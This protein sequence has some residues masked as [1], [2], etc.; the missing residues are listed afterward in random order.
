[1]RYA[2]IALV[3]GS[4]V[5]VAGPARAQMPQSDALRLASDVR[6][7]GGNCPA[8]QVDYHATQ[9]F[10]DR[11]GLINVFSPDGPMQPYLVQHDRQLN[12]G[13]KAVGQETMCQSLLDKYRS[14]GLLII[15]SAPELDDL[16]RMRSS[17][18]GG[19]IA[20]LK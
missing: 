5:L 18:G 9:R 7:V 4:A 15:R 3:L 16:N 6:W 17:N 10:M 8:L 19:P 11:S 14:T 20:P 2:S 13:L 12:D 1:M